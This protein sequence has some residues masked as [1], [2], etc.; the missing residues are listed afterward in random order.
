[1]EEGSRGGSEGAK[2]RGGCPSSSPELMDSREA[3]SYASYSPLILC[4][5]L[6]RL[7]DQSLCLCAQPRASR[8]VRVLPINS[9]EFRDPPIRRSLI[10]SIV[11]LRTES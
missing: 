8:R 11:L 5:L 7:N 3:P 10:F 9:D 6:R 2:E 1:M 4:R